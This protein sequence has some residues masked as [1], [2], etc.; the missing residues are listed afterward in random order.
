L[1]EYDLVVKNHSISHNAG[2]LPEYSVML[3]SDDPKMRLRL[4]SGSSAIFQ[5]YPRGHI[6]TMRLEKCAQQKLTDSQKSIESP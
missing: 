2:D 6:I 5:E 3:E 4:R 1:T